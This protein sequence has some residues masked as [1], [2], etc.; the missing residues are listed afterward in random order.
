MDCPE[1]KLMSFLNFGEKSLH[2]VR[3]FLGKET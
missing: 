3:A 2:D 1:D